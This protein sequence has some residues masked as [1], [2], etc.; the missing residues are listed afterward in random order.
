MAIQEL[1][2]FSEFLNESPDGVKKNFMDLGTRDKNARPFGYIEGVLY[3]GLVNTTHDDL[4]KKLDDDDLLSDD[5]YNEFKQVPRNAFKQ[6]GRFWAKNYIL[7]F[8]DFPSEKDFKQFRKDLE[9]ETKI[10]IFKAWDINVLPGAK[11][12]DTN[13]W[14]DNNTN[15]VL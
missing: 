7:S 13:A 10:K 3:V 4:F 6:S 1:P 5:V 14:Y 2:T 15:G 9:K 12:N 11:I 8:W